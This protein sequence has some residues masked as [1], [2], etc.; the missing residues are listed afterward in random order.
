MNALEYRGVCKTFGKV[1]AVKPL[2]LEVPEGRIFGL[3]GPN[4]AGKTTLIRMTLGIL[5]PDAGTVS[6]GGRPREQVPA[7]SLGYLPEE[8]GLYVKMKV[9][10]LLRFFGR[11][12]GLSAGEASRRA[13]DGL[14]RLGLEKWENNRLDELSKGMQQKIQLLVAIQHRPRVAILDE[15]FSGLDPVNVELF[16]EVLDEAIAQGTTVVLST[17]QMEQVEKLCQS[18]AL[19][20]QGRVVLRGDVGEIRKEYGTRAV[21]VEFSDGAELTETAF[22]DLSESTALLPNEARFFLRPEAHSGKILKRLLEMR[23]KVSRFEEAQASMHD[24][25]VKVVTGEDGHAN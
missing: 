11:L 10:E 21:K 14:K 6:V 12:R 2:D 8:R 5:L 1:E 15:P 19:I 7:S 16:M 25:F 3:L 13:A 22:A 20:H 4:G 9:G 23:V 17:H 18:I 24:I